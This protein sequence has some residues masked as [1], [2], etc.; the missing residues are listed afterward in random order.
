MITYTWKHIRRTPLYGLCLV[1]LTGIV[2]AVLCGL[3]AWNRQE[4]IRY[5]EIY[6]T[7]PVTLRVTDLSGSRWDKLKAPPYAAD[8]FTGD[9]TVKP[10][11]S[12][13]VKDLLIKS[14]RIVDT[15]DGRSCV[16]TLTGITD[17][18]AAPN[19]LPENAGEVTWLPG[20]DQ[21]ILKGE[22]LVCLVPQD[23]VHEGTLK[24]GFVYVT[25]KEGERVTWETEKTL[26]VVGTY[27]GS[28]SE[29]LYCPYSVVESVYWELKQERVIDSVSATLA[30]NDNLETFRERRK[31]WF[32]APN[33]LGEK[34]YWGSLY[35]YYP[36]ALDIDDSLLKQ[37]GEVLENS[38]RIN[39][40][41]T[42]ALLLLSVG[43]GFFLGFLM[44]RSRKREIALLRTMG[45][46][47]WQIFLSFCGEQLLYLMAGILAC[48]AFWGWD[49]VQKLILFAGIYIL[50]LT[51][52]LL[53]F[54]RKN[55]MATIKED[56]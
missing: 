47:D 13:D 40:L 51:L 46:A 50:G 3:Q 26:K 48:G 24:L 16:N 43:A 53:V 8:V 7:I 4:Q 32:A 31:E 25:K 15:I 2:A 55:L 18:R 14:S 38:L 21:E 30:D 6:K 33:V 1:L 36:L 28:G 45:T 10:D 9:W 52:A 29:V 41:C 5:R 27:K 35:D 23:M 11:F 39:Q 12:Q 56:E 20:Y 22:E 34:T 49:P 44:V 17:L 42:A 37:A 54:L 19:L